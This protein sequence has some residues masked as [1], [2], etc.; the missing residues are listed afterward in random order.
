MAF[1]N[2]SDASGTGVAFTRDPATGEKKL[3]GEFLLNHSHQGIFPVIDFSVFHAVGEVSD[4]WVCQKEF[5]F[6]RAFH[7][8]HFRKGKLC[9]NFSCSFF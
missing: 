8:F 3:M 4:A 6:F 7:A 1:G 5:R 2:W 9:L